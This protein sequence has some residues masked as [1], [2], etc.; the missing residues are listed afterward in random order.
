MAKRE[1]VWLVEYSGDWFEILGFACKTKRESL[2]TCA[3][4][5]RQSREANGVVPSG[6]YRPAFYIRA[7]TPKKLKGKRHA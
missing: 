4:L 3:Q 1:G 6:E 7:T 2:A 5:R